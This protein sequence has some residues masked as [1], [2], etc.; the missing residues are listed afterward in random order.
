[1]GK[2]FEVDWTETKLMDDLLNDLFSAVAEPLR[3]LT[4][5]VHR[6]G[7][8]LIFT[9]AEKRL[10]HAVSNLTLNNWGCFCSEAVDGECVATTFAR[11]RYIEQYI[12]V[13]RGNS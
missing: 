7:R 13:A 2:R 6:E 8:I 5:Q 12:V 1:M 3:G 11:A 10:I 4:M 9:D